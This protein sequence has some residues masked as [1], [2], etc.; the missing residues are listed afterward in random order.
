MKKEYVL[1]NVNVI[2]VN[3]DVVIE[4]TNV[5]VKDGKIQ[6]F[7]KKEGVKTIDCNGQYLLPGL[8]NMHVHLF[9]TGKPSNTLN[10]KGNSQANLMKFLKTPLGGVV[11][12]AIVKGKLKTAINAGT[13]T[14]RAVG[15]ILYSDVKQR[16]AINSGKYIGPRVLCS[17]QAISSVGGHGHGTITLEAS[18]KEEFEALVQQNYD[19]GCDLIKLMITSGVMDAKADAVDLMM[20]VEQVKWVCDYAHKLGLKVAAHIESTEG[21]KVALKGGVDSIEHG[22]DLDQECID[23]FKKT[24]STLTTTISPAITYAA[25]SI[26]E[27]H[28]TEIQKSVCDKVYGG[29]AKSSRQAL[30]NGIKVGLG[31]DASCPYAFHY[32][33]WRELAYFKKYVGVTN[34]FAIKTATILNAKILGLDKE[35]GSIEKGKDADMMLVK[36]NPYKDIKTLEQPVMVVKSGAI[37]NN[38]KIKRFEYFEKQLDGLCF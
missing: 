12:N 13:T 20:T 37:I 21:V 11:L 35:I 25:F 14:V 29:I 3:K 32:G 22:S 10:A 31:T 1:T 30:D 5:Y 34:E 27:T 6:G 7:E 26:E 33:M 9:S 18:T 17:G 36:A 19:K 4:N 28:C 16:D 8:I 38:P 15:D 2:D 23:L 24:G